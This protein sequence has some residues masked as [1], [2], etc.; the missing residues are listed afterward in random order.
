MRT[1][2]AVV[3]TA[4]LVSLTGGSAHA[5]VRVSVYSQQI[6]EQTNGVRA[7][8][9]RPKLALNSCMDGYADSWAKHLATQKKA[10]VHRSS[11]SLQA[12]MKKCGLRS[13]GENLAF[14]YPDG[15]S[16]VGRSTDKVCS[17]SCSK[18]NWM[19][20]GGH[21]AN[22]MNAAF[23]GIGVGAWRDSNDRYYSVALYGQPR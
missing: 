13:I 23:R 7:K 9:D 22:Q 21:R 2:I 14:G 19:T 18:V 12:I 16:V 10:L 3:L 1:T 15:R 5:V 11:A 17:S 6:L 4:L 20:S 8:F